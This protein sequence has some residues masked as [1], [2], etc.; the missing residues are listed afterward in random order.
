MMPLIELH[1]Q[2]KTLLG[3]QHMPVKQALPDENERRVKSCRLS[4]HV[5]AWQL[6]GIVA[7]PHR[8]LCSCT[9]QKTGWIRNSCLADTLVFPTVVHG[10]LLSS[11]NVDGEI[12]N[13][14]RKARFGNGEEEGPNDATIRSMAEVNALVAKHIT[15]VLDLSNRHKVAHV[16]PVSHDDSPRS[17]YP[18]STIT[19]ISKT[20]PLSIAASLV[21][22]TAAATRP[23]FG[24][25]TYLVRPAKRN[26]IVIW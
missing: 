20:V 26:P 22:Q 3:I 7:I 15:H 12:L 4:V 9:V 10:I 1:D 21:Q 6:Y 18:S 16:T 24:A 5:C 23:Y 8:G 11:V 25:T 19:G 14:N 13:I 17:S 2:H